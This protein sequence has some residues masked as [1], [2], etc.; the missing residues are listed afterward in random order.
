[1]QILRYLTALL[2]LTALPWV[3]HS[4][5]APTKQIAAGATTTTLVISWTAP[6]AHVDGTA[7]TESLTYN[8]YWGVG[9]CGATSVLA[10]RMNTTPITALTYTVTGAGPGLKC[11][12][13]TAVNAAGESSQA[14][15]PP[16]AISV[17]PAPVA[18]PSKPNAPTSVQVK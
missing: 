17:L 8:A 18:A 14:P 3:A 5:T 9:P 10:S 11:F 2:M 16:F 13:V 1:M 7:V 4:Q 12:T 6:T 15:A